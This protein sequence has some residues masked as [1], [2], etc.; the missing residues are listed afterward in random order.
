M[1]EKYEVISLDTRDTLVCTDSLYDAIE[2]LT[3]YNAEILDI[4]TN[5]IENPLWITA[6]YGMDNYQFFETRDMYLNAERLTLASRKRIA[7]LLT[8]G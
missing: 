6:Y 8:Q 5:D 7:K 4:N 1:K 3:G 2:D